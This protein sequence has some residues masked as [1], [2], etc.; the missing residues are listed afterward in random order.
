MIELGGQKPAG[1]I[2]IASHPRS[3]GFTK[4]GYSKWHPIEPCFKYPHGIKRIH[5]TEKHL[6]D[7]GFGPLKKWASKYHEEAEHLENRI[8][9]QLKNRR[10]TDVGTSREIFDISPEDAQRIVESIFNDNAR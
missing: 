6:V 8:H 4:I 5:R 9:K 2:Y 1:W 7:I 10:R 3:E